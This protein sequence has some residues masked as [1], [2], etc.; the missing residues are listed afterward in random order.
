MFLALLVSWRA[1]VCC[2]TCVAPVAE[3]HRAPQPR[4][5]GV[6]SPH[7]AVSLRFNN[8]HAKNRRR[9][10][11]RVLESAQ[12]EIWAGLAALRALNCAPECRSE[13]CGGIEAVRLDG[14][15]AASLALVDS[16]P[17]QD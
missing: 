2:G 1:S 5:R 13:M 14:S 9:S 16:I 15:G 17:L 3:R 4:G 10:P 11:N 6:A 7:Q 8:R 12:P